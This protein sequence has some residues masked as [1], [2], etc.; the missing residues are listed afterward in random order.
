MVIKVSV[1]ELEFFFKLRT[2]VLGVSLWK[3][4]RR[5]NST[6]ILKDKCETEQSEGEDQKGGHMTEEKS[7]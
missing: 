4:W 3:V 1:E 7:K 2:G 6:W 5:W